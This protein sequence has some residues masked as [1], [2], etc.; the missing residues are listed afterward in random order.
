DGGAPS[1]AR[2]QAQLDLHG[3]VAAA[4]EDLAGMDLLDLAHRAPGS[5]LS[6]CL[7]VELQLVV[8][9]E[10][11]PLAAGMAGELLGGLDALLKTRR[12]GAQRELG[13][14]AQLASDVHRR[15][16]D[17]AELVED[18]VALTLGGFELLELAADRVV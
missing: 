12:R 17:V 16:Q 3:G 10:L 4:V 9:L 6:R 1:R 13:I 7:C 11:P 15:E 8:G 2:A 14:H 18:R 5:S